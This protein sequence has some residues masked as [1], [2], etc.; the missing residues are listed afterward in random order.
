MY[1]PF[2]EGRICEAKIMYKQACQGRIIDR[3]ETLRVCYP[4][5][6]FFILYEVVAR[7]QLEQD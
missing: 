1:P 6:A 3:G 4:Y 7:A 2:W 5:R